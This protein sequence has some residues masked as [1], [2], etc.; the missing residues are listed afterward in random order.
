MAFHN[1]F[2]K[3]GVFA[4]IMIAAL[5]SVSNETAAIS[6]DEPFTSSK[7]FASILNGIAT[8]VARLGI[9]VVGFFLVYTGFTFVT[10]QG[11]KEKLKRAR[12]MFVWTIVGAAVVLGAPFIANLIIDFAQRL[13]AAK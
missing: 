7:D 8:F 13:G 9:P 10:A 6:L 11:N 3:T 4:I 1:R 2:F 12:T 5:L